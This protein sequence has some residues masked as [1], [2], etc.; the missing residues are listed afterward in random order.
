MKKWKFDNVGHV[1]R[2]GMD[3]WEKTILEWV[4]RVAKRRVEKPTTRWEDKIVQ[5]IPALLEERMSELGTIGE[6]WGRPMPVNGRTKQ[7]L[8]CSNKYNY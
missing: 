6:K 8:F 1:A 4:P 3:R 2:E 5:H 7:A